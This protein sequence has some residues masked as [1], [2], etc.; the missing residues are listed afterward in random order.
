M[1]SQKTLRGWRPNLPS[2]ISA[3]P[4]G[5]SRKK[6]SVAIK[7]GAADEESLHNAADRAV[8]TVARGVDEA[9]QATEEQ[10]EYWDLVH[11]RSF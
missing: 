4:A 9:R 2:V 7:G 3:L 6:S 11:V 8:V 5:E 10:G 1:S